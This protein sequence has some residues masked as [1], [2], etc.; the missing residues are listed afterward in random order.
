M[1]QVINDIL[2]NTDASSRVL[3]WLWVAAPIALLLA[4][5]AEYKDNKNTAAFKKALDKRN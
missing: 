1:Y 5:V 3:F 2:Y 4:G